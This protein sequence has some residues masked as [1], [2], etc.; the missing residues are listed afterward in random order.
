[1]AMIGSEKWCNAR[2][3]SYCTKSSRS[4]NSKIKQQNIYTRNI[5]INVGVISSGDCLRKSTNINDK[6]NCAEIYVDQFMLVF[7][8]QIKF[9]Q[10]ILM[11]RFRLVSKFKITGM[12]LN[13]VHG[14][15][16]K[17][18]NTFKKEV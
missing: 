3:G 4:K 1:M 15:V 13:V 11:K 12:L 16:Q 7:C 9:F 6:N 8:S 17:L 5:D 18:T 2:N 10:D 14:Q